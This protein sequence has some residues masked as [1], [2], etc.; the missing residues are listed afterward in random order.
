MSRSH[1]PAFTLIELLVVI[2]IIAI[3][4]GLLLPAVQKVRE[5]A[6]RIKCQ[7]NLKQITLAYHMHDNDRGKLP[8]ALVEPPK[9]G[10]TVYLLPYLEQKALAEMYRWDREWNAPETA[11]V[12]NTPL[13]VFVC[14]S[15]P[16][17]DRIARVTGPPSWTAAPA[18]YGANAG[19]SINQIRQTY[20]DPE[21]RNSPA[22]PTGGALTHVT[23]GT[24]N[25][26]LVLECAGRPD[27]YE[28]GRFVQS[29][30]NSLEAGWA[31]HR[32][33]CFLDGG[34]RTPPHDN[35]ADC[36]MNCYNANE[37]YS[38]HPGGVNFAFCD[39]SVRFIRESIEFRV[40]GRLWTARAG[41]V[42]A[43]GDF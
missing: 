25:T 20:L 26:L 8:P 41:E 28:M 13:K 11:S 33:S 2:A 35:F 6:A 7:N 5:A 9:H 24:S 15:A 34:S 12:I 14:P 42:V 32:S 22:G 19:I 23:D 31:A 39:G 17:G 30:R 27:Q 29:G 36:P 40:Y 4:I 38:F 43:A 21:T 3:L 10:W 37:A 18:D 1:R 16:G